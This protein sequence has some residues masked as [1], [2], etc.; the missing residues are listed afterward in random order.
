MKRCL[1][2]SWRRMRS[3]SSLWHRHSH[4]FL[5]CVCVY[6]CVSLITTLITVSVGTWA[7]LFG[8]SHIICCHYDALMGNHLMNS[9]LVIASLV[10][11]AGDNKTWHCTKK[12]HFRQKRRKFPNNYQRF[13]T[14]NT[15]LMTLCLV[16]T[17]NLSFFFKAEL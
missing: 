1:L 12:Q 10:C 13:I 6:V 11:Q 3:R 9:T 16:S 7:K 8:W 5:V 15:V 14:Q 4:L 17:P 2:S